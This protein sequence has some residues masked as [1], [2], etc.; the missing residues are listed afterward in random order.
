MMNLENYAQL[1]QSQVP[2]ELNADLERV[3]RDGE[4]LGRQLFRRD[5]RELLATALVVIGFSAILLL[6]NGWLTRLGA[7]LTLV[8]CGLTFWQLLSARRLARTPADAPLRAQLQA[9]LR[10]LDRQIR[11]LRKV[12]WWY[13]LPL[14]GGA[15]LVFAGLSGLWWW[16]L[17]YALAV[18]AF[19]A[20]V[21]WLNQRAWR[22]K[23]WPQ[24]QRLAQL[25]DRL[26]ATD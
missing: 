13:L 24:R 9:E 6:G 15:V 14:L 19:G 1:W 25:I 23:L 4:R 7:G 11:L 16:S 5:L 3:R 17:G 10:G 20:W 8:G 2:P 26:E 12:L 18:L 21:W 22:R